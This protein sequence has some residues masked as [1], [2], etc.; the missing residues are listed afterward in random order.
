LG[1]IKEEIVTRDCQKLLFNDCPGVSRNSFLKALIKA[2]VSEKP[3][4]AATSGML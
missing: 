2:D 1:R 4:I 3:V